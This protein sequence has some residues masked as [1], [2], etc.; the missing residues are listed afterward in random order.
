VVHEN[1]HA[2]FSITPESTNVLRSTIS[3]TDASISTT[4]WLWDFGDRNTSP[5]PNPQEH[6]YADTGTYKIRLIVTN[7]LC[8]DSTSEIVRITLPTTLY[9]PNTFSPNGDGV[10]DVFKAEGDGITKFEMMVYDR[11]G[12]MVFYSTDINKGWDGKVNGGSE[13]SVLDTYVYVINITAFAN[14][15]DYTYRG[16]VNLIK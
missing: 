2:I 5:S 15:H 13:V 4:S 11:W 8:K 12:Q 16:T 14:K 3:I 1:P 10:N 7:S 6:T 9:V